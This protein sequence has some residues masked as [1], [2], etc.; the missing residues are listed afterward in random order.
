MA[1]KAIVTP[2][3]LPQVGTEL[4]VETFA[5]IGAPNVI[6][7]TNNIVIGSGE[8]IQIDGTLLVNGTMS[9]SGV[10]SG[11]TGGT[12]GA[13]ALNGLNDVSIASVNLGDVLKWDGSSWVNDTDAGLTQLNLPQLA[14]VASTTPQDGDILQYE[15]TS[16]NWNFVNNTDFIDSI[17]DGGEASSDPHYVLAF[18]IDGGRA[19]VSGAYWFADRLQANGVPQTPF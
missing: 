1:I 13:T 17:I 9:G 18:D 6:V 14:D 5:R 19:L 12:G 2:Q 16:Q 10:P 7:P 4:S 15:S 3:G 11:G 8:T